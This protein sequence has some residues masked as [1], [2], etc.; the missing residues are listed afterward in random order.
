LRKI[1]VT[2]KPATIAA[3]TCV[4]V[5]LV[6]Y[7]SFDWI[8][9]S[10]A[11]RR[12]TQQ[13]DLMMR[14]FQEAME[15]ARKDLAR[16][17]AFEALNCQNGAS[18]SL[19]LR[20]FDNEYVRWYGV[21]RNGT[22]VCSS[23]IV[24]FDL[25]P[26]RSRYRLNDEWSAAMV[27][28][29]WGG[30][31][32]LVIQT[33]GEMRYMAVLQPLLFDFES[34]AEC[35]KCVSYAGSMG[36]N[37]EIQIQSGMTNEPGAISF[38]RQTVVFGAPVRLTYSATQEY[39]AGFTPTGRMLA[40]GIAAIVSLTL[41]FFVYWL[42]MRRTSVDSVLRRGLRDDEFLP[43]Y[44][45]IVD[46]RNGTVLGAE[47]LAR[48]YHGGK[49][50][51][52]AQFI[53][54]AEESGLIR[55]ITEQLVKKVLRDLRRFGWVGTDRYI[56]I[57]AV[58]DQ[59]QK[60]D[61]CEVLVKQLEESGI[62]G[63]NFAVEITER[64][65][66]ADLAEGRRHLLVLSGAGVDVKIDDAGTGFGGFSYV[67]ELPVSTLKI[68]KMFIDTLR[69]GGDAKRSVLD[70]IIKFAMTSGLETIAEGVETVEQIE[71]LVA[72]GVHAIQGYVYARPMPASELMKWIEAGGALKPSQGA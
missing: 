57:N 68:D 70:A 31:D 26:P 24:R 52:P 67:Q 61:F 11:T 29:F 65:K 8:P 17:P 33:R 23:P 15:S 43:Y 64:R 50:I 28:P 48:W 51:P 3:I 63:R 21:E 59:I 55:P 72:L 1:H 20:E 53:P 49:L 60:T 34:P 6:C 45:P 54:F 14:G 35:V 12:L 58:P 36:P 27:H 40:A 9:R 13:A 47:A 4:V 10:L 2:D 66:L 42:M 32:L 19:A 44:Q 37:H 69:A 62:P 30:D 56:S 46:A 25:P 71:Q 22:I 7:F 16:L 39:V 41:S 5:F 18:P 38:I